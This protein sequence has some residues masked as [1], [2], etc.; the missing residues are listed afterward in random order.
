MANERYIDRQLGRIEAVGAPVCIGLD[1][2]VARLPA[3]A[4]GESD[5]HRVSAFCRGVI[6]R[7]AE[8]AAAFKPQSAC[9]ERFGSAG[10]GAL[11]ETVAH[12]RAAGV[13][14]IYDAKRGDIGSTAEHYAA[15]AVRLGVDA[16][17][18]NAYMGPSTIE[19]YLEAGLGVFALVRTSNPDSDRVQSVEIDG[20]LTVAE[21]VARVIY[22]AGDKHR[23]GG[24]MSNLG[25]VVGLTKF[26]EAFSLR[27]LMPWQMFLVPGYGAQGGSLDD[28]GMVLWDSAGPGKGVLVNASRSIIYSDDIADAARRMHEDLRRVVG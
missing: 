8:F 5:A 21:H 9:F 11:E 26:R 7:T 3:W 18:V 2:V 13:P 25:A 16:I 20:H 22:E 24:R 15:A 10:F 14:V 17:T 6:D 27:R 28:L 4:T 12:A 19:P 1:P 23:N